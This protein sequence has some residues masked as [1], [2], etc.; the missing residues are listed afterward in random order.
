M[1]L[2]SGYAR[3]LPYHYTSSAESILTNPSQIRV[4]LY[5]LAVSGHVL[6]FLFRSAELSNAIESSLGV[7][8]L[9]IFLTTVIMTARRSLGL[10]HAL[11]I[12][13]L[14]G[15]VGL[16]ARPRGRYPT[17]AVRQHVFTA[18]YVL[19][20][21]GSLAYLIFVFATAPG[22]GD[23]PECNDSTV[24]V[25]F[26]VN[27]PATNPVLRWML[28]AGLAI[29]L[30]G[31][32]VWLLI[33]A[34]ISV[35][36]V[37]RGDNPWR[38]QDGY[39]DDGGD[40]KHRQRW[41]ELV[42]RLA[43]TIY[44]AVMLELMITRNTL[45]PGAGEWTFGQVLAMTMLVGPLIELASLLLGKVDRRRDGQLIRA[46]STSSPALARRVRGTY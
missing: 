27:I 43:G 35:D 10:F 44:L 23:R 22:F 3:S 38:A 31:I 36:V 39:D 6:P 15:I 18:F 9:A 24:Y 20:T 46:T 32:V 14:V 26:G 4:S 16:S 40:E 45:A 5:V 7:T 33:V 21:A 13:H 41:F 1:W 2:E 28:V 19:V 42:G 25:I 12:F 34:C 29:L 30:M 8:G 37:V 11:C 17:G